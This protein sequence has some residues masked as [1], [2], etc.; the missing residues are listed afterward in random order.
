MTHERASMHQLRAGRSR[1]SCQQ[2][3]LCSNSCLNVISSACIMPV[4]MLRAVHVGPD[5][6]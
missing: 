5:E 4:N 6:Y 2:S 1:Q 3:C